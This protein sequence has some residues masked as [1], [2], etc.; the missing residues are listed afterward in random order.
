MASGKTINSRLRID[1]WKENQPIQ[2]FYSL[3]YRDYALFW[4]S[5]LLGS[6]G[7]FV[8]EVALYWIA[9]EITGSAMALGILGLCGAAPRLILG[10]LGGVLVDRYDRKLLLILIQFSSTVPA[11]IFLALYCLGSARV[12]APSR[13]G[14]SF[15]IDPLHKPV[16]VPIHPRRVGAARASNECRLAIHHRL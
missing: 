12:L 9:Y 2:I 6:V 14:D 13:A 5:D 16:G 4:S 15:R 10:A 1:V 11:F 8:Q 7:H 3:R